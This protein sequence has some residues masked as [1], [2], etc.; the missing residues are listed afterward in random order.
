ML[1]VSV[2][3]QFNTIW[4]GGLYG[5]N[6]ALFG[7][8]NKTHPDAEDAVYAE[9]DIAPDHRVQRVILDEYDHSSLYCVFG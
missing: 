7:I 4:S 9:I 2:E 6:Y 1:Q 5:K 8:R 3:H